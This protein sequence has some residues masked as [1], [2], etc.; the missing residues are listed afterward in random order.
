[1]NFVDKH[2]TKKISYDFDCFDS[3]DREDLI[4]EAFKFMLDE[5]DNTNFRDVKEMLEHKYN[6]P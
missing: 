5:I 1:M 6:I 3:L 2:N 4:Y